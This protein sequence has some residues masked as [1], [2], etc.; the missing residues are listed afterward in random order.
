MGNQTKNL[1]SE[2]SNKDLFAEYWMKIN[3]II[4][5]SI[6][7]LIIVDFFA[8]GFDANHICAQENSDNP[9]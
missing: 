1:Q 7:V 3:K 4:N 6:L 2:Y 5:L 9:K 8:L